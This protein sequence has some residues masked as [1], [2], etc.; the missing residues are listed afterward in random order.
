[1]LK[2][3]PPWIKTKIPFG[4]NFLKLKKVIKS[5]NIHTI[6]SEALCPNLGECSEKGIA[7]FLVLGDKC[8][9]NCLYCNVKFGKPDSVDLSEPT[10]IAKT[11]KDLGLKYVVVTSVTRDDLYDG[12]AGIFVDTINQIKSFAP[13]CNIE[14]LIPD[15][16]G[17][18]ESTN[19]I[20][21]AKPLVFA[22]N[23]ETTENFYNIL[24]PQGNYQMSLN[25]LKSAKIIYPD[26]I[27]KSGIMVGFGETIKHII[28]SMKDIRESGVN[29]F[30]LGQY[31]QPSRNHY[32]V[33]KYYTPDE[34]KYLEQEG[35]ELGFSFVKA[36]P[37]VR[38]SYMAEEIVK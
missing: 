25:V 31:L 38:S 33:K 22:H 20:L 37:L 8:T 19:E 18:R 24:R 34:F 32:P 9:R 11:V 7:T 36:G 12:G 1:M 29:I 2:R 27:S 26:Q 5:N 35:Y 4:N 10:R 6:C 30:T 16:M 28:K 3:K 15:F 13:S 21:K 17:K 14:V 23:L